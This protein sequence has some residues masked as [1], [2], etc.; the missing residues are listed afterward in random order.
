[1][2]AR[3]VEANPLAESMVNQAAVT[4]GP[5]V[6][7]LESPDLPADV[8]IT[9]VRL[10]RDAAFEL[11]SLSA[12][13]SNLRGLR[14]QV[15]IQ[16]GPS[17]NRNAPLYSPVNGTPTRREKLTLIPY[18]AWNNRGEPHMRVWLPLAN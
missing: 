9:E 6:Y 5:L 12:P 11:V 17:A 18:F 14:G 15:L 13:L 8:A 1:M 2:R 7:C 3:L 4:C 10:P 16:P